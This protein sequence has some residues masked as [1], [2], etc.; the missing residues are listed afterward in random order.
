MGWGGTGLRRSKFL[1]PSQLFPLFFFSTFF[2][3]PSSAVHSWSPSKTI[4][5][6]STRGHKAPLMAEA[7]AKPTA[8]EGSRGP[9]ARPQGVFRGQGC[10]GVGVG[11]QQGPQP[12]AQPCSWLG[13]WWPL[14]PAP[15]VEA[16]WLFSGQP[17]G[18]SCPPG[19][20]E[21]GCQPAGRSAATGPCARLTDGMAFALDGP[22]AAS[23]STCGLQGPDGHT[24][25][26][27][28]C[29]ESGCWRQN[30]RV[31][32]FSF[33]PSWKPRGLAPRDPPE[34]SSER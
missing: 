8:G 32:F 20:A 5:S 23:V 27:A 7:G 26:L 34:A 22:S 21:G 13:G 18:P 12:R 10:T 15:V 16:P 30:V 2:Q 6:G 14:S 31:W 25:A 17:R 9:L 11:A 19:S 3:K 4:G 33:L 1:L 24:A 29:L 28:E